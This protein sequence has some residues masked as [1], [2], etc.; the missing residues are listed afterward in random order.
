[1]CKFFSFRSDGAG[2]YYYLNKKQRVELREKG[3]ED[4]A[5]SHSF[6]SEYYGFKGKDDDLLNKYEYNP[7][8]KDFTI[9]N[10]VSS[11]MDDSLAA[12]Q[13]VE[14][15][16]FDTIIVPLETFDFKKHWELFID[17]SLA[18]W[19]K[20]E[21]AANDFLK[22][23][24]NQGMTWF[25]GNELNSHNNWETYK[26]N[27]YYVEGICFGEIDNCYGSGR[28]TVIFEEIQ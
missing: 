12:K 11:K 15:L 21:K 20:T 28:R 26:E 22:Y 7:F 3:K 25:S 1:M 4:N 9:D 23:C 24:A 14:N 19:C 13:W 27:T 16:D 18:V 10:I 17:D 5:D 6:I 8:T 2:K